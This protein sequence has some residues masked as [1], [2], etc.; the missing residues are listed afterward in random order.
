ME[1]KASVFSGDRVLKGLF[2][3]LLIRCSVPFLGMLQAWLERGALDDPFGEFMIRRRVEIDAPLYGKNTQNLTAVG[4][5]LPT[6]IIR[7]SLM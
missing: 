3:D 2:E 1:E 5:L 4:F 6:C 7:F